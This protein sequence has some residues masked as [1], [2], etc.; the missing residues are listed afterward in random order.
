MGDPTPYM[1]PHGLV[2]SAGVVELLLET[3]PD[4]ATLRDGKGRT[5]LH[6]AAEEEQHDV[7]Q[8]V[9]ETPQFSSILNAQDKNGDT[10]LHRAV[11]AGNVAI[12]RYLSFGIGRLPLRPQHPTSMA[13]SKLM[14]HHSSRPYIVAV[15]LSALQPIS[16]RLVHR[17]CNLGLTSSIDDPSASAATTTAPP[18]ATERLGDLLNRSWAWPDRQSAIDFA[19]STVDFTSGAA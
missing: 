13:L 19:C 18:D 1:L 7:V 11:H 4:S 15:E 3:C 10:P 8:Y 12:F 5:F 16:C 6:V 9:C 14:L 2:T 17:L